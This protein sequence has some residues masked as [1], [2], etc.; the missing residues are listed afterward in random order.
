MMKVSKGCI[1]PGQFSLVSLLE[2]HVRADQLEVQNHVI[3]CI[4]KTVDSV[5]QLRAVT[6]C[7]RN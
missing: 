6:K 3:A 1:G 7:L 5:Y 2:L 4:S